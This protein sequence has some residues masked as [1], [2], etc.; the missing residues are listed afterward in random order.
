MIMDTTNNSRDHRPRYQEKQHET[1][2][3]TARLVSYE[4][5]RSAYEHKLVDPEID[6]SHIE[7]I[8]ARAMN[9]M[10]AETISPLPREDKLT[11][12]DMVDGISA[13]AS[14]IYALR[15]REMGKKQDDFGEAS[16]V[17]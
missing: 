8:G 6:T 9:M 2:E 16:E 15:Y 12:Q 7:G 17:A 5:A 10:R 4:H 3:S 14:S 1:A 13:V 11:M